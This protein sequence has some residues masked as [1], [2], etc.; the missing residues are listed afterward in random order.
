MNWNKKKFPWT[1]YYYRCIA[2]TKRHL[3]YLKYIN[4][5]HSSWYW[6]AACPTLLESGKLKIYYMCDWMPSVIKI[7]TNFIEHYSVFFQLVYEQIKW[8]RKMHRIKFDF[9]LIVWVRCNRK[10]VFQV[11]LVLKCD[12]WMKVLSRFLMVPACE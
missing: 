9:L 1:N 4:I 6:K 10:I 3:A 5:K 2:N 12:A 7:A 11:R 8:E